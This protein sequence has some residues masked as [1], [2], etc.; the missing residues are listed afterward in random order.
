MPKEYPRYITVSQN[1]FMA[2]N[3]VRGYGGTCFLKIA[4]RRKL[5]I[6]HF[7]LLTTD[8]NEHRDL[9]LVIMQRMRVFG[10]LKPPWAIYTTY[11]PF[12]VQSSSGKEDKKKL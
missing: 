7:L 5:A 12:K 3:S 11:L 6:V 2:F 1:F 10:M 8:V 9:K 4:I